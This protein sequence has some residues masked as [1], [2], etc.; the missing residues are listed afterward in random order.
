MTLSA[1]MF[2]A[3]SARAASDPNLLW[4]SIET[5][6]FRISYY[7]GEEEIARK[8]AMLAEDIHARLVPAVGWASTERTEIALSDNTDSANGS[9][10][11]LPYNAIRLYVTAPDDLSPL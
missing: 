4:H 3:Q 2:A 7:S 5:K 9:A 11:A 8:V 6:H 1:C 10:T